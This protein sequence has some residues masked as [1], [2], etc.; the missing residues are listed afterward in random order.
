MEV[1]QKQSEDLQAHKKSVEESCQ[2]ADQ[3]LTAG[4][5]VQFLS[6]QQFVKKRLSMLQAQ[7]RDGSGDPESELYAQPKADH[8]IEFTNEKQADVLGTVAAMGTVSG[9]ATKKKKVY[10]PHQKRHN[11]YYSE[12]EEDW[13][14]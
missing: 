2:F 11:S 12:Y 3:V 14:S 6:V 9:K 7:I 4:N 5:N 1:L 8:V 13:R 10:T